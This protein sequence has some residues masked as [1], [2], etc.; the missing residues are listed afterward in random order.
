M[1]KY[2]RY[3]A[4]YS[5]QNFCERRKTGRRPSEPQPVKRTVKKYIVFPTGSQA[6]LAAFMRRGKACAFPSASGRP[7]GELSAVI[8][9]PLQNAP[10]ALH[11]AV[12]NA[13]RHAGHTLR[14]SRLVFYGLPLKLRTVHTVPARHKCGHSIRFI[15]SCPLTDRILRNTPSSRCFT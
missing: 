15:V 13:V 4:R 10:E 2:T 8:A 3:T 12:I 5:P 11:R 7:D 14:H 6:L 1:R 9:F